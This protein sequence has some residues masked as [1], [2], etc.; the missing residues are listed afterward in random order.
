MKWWACPIDEQDI[1]VNKTKAF[2]IERQTKSLRFSFTQSIKRQIRGTQEAPITVMKK[3]TLFRLSFLLLA[4]LLPNVTFAGSDNFEVDGIYYYTTG[5]YAYVETPPGP[6]GSGYYYDEN[7]YSGDL[8]IPS[9]V[10]YYGNQLPVIGISIKG[11]NLTSITIPNSVTSIG[12]GCPNLISIKVASDN[13]KYDSR[14]NCN[15]IIETASNTLIKGCN[16][17]VIPNSVTSIG[18]SAFYGYSG[19]TSINI[20]NSVTSIGDNAFSRSGL[21][22]ITIPNSVTSIGD[23]FSGCTG[24]TNVTIGNSVTTIGSSAFRECTS[25]TNVT[26]GNSVT[27]IGPYAFT[28]CSSLTRVDIPNSVTSIGNNAFL[29][30]TGLTNVTIGNSVTEIDYMAFKYCDA[31]ETVKCLGTVPPVIRATNAFSTAAYDNAV[32]L[33]P[34]N[35][36]TLYQQAL[37][38]RKFIHIQSWGNAGIG[39]VNGDGSVT[40][41]DV[42]SLIDLL[43]DNG[44]VPE[45]GDVNGDGFVTI[46]DVTALIDMLLG[47]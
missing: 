29:N 45:V 8:T 24:L 46:A 7:Y 39:D 12:L 17:T 44:S 30:C 13:P 9:T 27:D 16:S 31:L 14:E 38:W 33:V 26:I 35:S 22:E 1:F 3:L 37:G 32:L 6:Y 47:S 20:P 36:I 21:T 2:C 23:A 18:N 43:L 11:P 4:L 41:A 34:L 40:I 15:G 25:L 19:L 42:T 5:D 10:D 28:D